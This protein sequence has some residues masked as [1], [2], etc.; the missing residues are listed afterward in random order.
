MT[1]EEQL[2]ETLEPKA[3]EIKESDIELPDPN[4]TPPFLL[5]SKK[6]RQK[7]GAQ[8]EFLKQITSKKTT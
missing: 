5:S 3:P 7:V 8:L 4:Y 1:L 2:Q 6:A